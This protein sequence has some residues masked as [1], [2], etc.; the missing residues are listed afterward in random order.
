MSIQTFARGG[1]SGINYIPWVL[2]VDEYLF[3]KVATSIGLLYRARP[4]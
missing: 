1:K 3:W 4:R 2:L